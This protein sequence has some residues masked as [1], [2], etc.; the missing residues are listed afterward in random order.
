[1]QRG[2]HQ[3]TRFR[4]TRPIPRQTCWRFAFTLELATVSTLR[5]SPAAPHAASARQNTH[6][7]LRNGLPGLHIAPTHSQDLRHRAALGPAGSG[8]G[9]DRK[10]AGGGRAPR[11]GGARGARGGVRARVAARRRRR[12]RGQAV[13]HA[14]RL[15]R[16]GRRGLVPKNCGKVPLPVAPLAEG[17]A[18][19]AAAPMTPRQQA[20]AR[21]EEERVRLN[22]PQGGRPRTQTQASRNSEAGGGQLRVLRVGHPLRRRVLP[23]RRRPPRGRPE[24]ARR[25]LGRVCGRPFGAV[26]VVLPR[27]GRR[28]GLRAD[29][30]ARR[31]SR[32]P[33]GRRSTRPTCTGCT[34][35]GG[36]ATSRG[37]RRAARRAR[38]RG[39]GSAC[40]TKRA[41][42]S[43]TPRR[44]RSACGAASRCTSASRS[45]ASAQLHKGF[46]HQ[47]W[48]AEEEK[49]KKEEAREADAHTAARPACPPPTSHGARGA[50]PPQARKLLEAQRLEFT[51]AICTK[52]ITAEYFCLPADD[53][54]PP[55]APER[56]VHACCEGRHT[57]VMLRPGG[58]AQYYDVAEGKLHTE[59]GGVARRLAPKCLQCGLPASGKHYPVDGGRLHVGDAG[60]WQLARGAADACLARSEPIVA[61][62]Y[63]LAEGRSTRQLL[64]RGRETQRT[65]QSST[66][67]TRPP[68][69][70]P[71]RRSRRMYRWRRRRRRRRPTPSSARIDARGCGGR[72]RPP[73]PPAR[74]GRDAARRARRRRARMVLQAGAG[75]QVAQSGG[76]RRCARG[77][78]CYYADAA[79][80]KLKGSVALQG[81]ASRSASFAPPAAT[82]RAS[83]SST[84]R[85]GGRCSP[86]PTRRGAAP[87][88]TPRGST[89]SRARSRS[90]RRRS[91]GRR[92]RRPLPGGAGGARAALADPDRGRGRG[93]GGARGGRGRRGR[94]R[95][96][97][98][99]GLTL[100]E[101]A[102]TAAMP[103]RSAKIESAAQATRTA[104]KDFARAARRSPPLGRDSSRKG[105]ASSRRCTSRARG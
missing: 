49:R 18:D 79:C 104:V 39:R 86:S 44:G 5:R 7:A 68:P 3:H 69:P 51:C 4:T 54:A 37:C 42:R 11:E 1:M 63:A 38:S 12:R 90:S 2:R 48:T 76:G 22:D 105:S 59:L 100:E 23:A 77:C 103:S 52:Q 47:Q 94:R 91:R 40:S 87:R 26:P 89:C 6:D 53:G 95:R 71:A 98:R 9:R 32:P 56:K 75:G 10:E 14:L 96:R 73:P 74:R 82:R 36:A 99:R 16:V 25:M 50:H 65:C 21:L 60:S 30:A 81:A 35:T 58:D 20:A 67:A 43:T 97:P 92:R 78:L 72:G 61:Q 101:A 45:R 83:R 31:P 15:P 85:R 8:C 24:G 28:R 13:L 57:C 70:P 19:A 55:D 64:G 27:G 17:G 41:S 88:R 93:G 29:D 66:R 33:R 62:H 80:T 102:V 84:S 46:C 34:A